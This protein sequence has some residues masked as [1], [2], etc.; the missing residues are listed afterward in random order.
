MNISSTTSKYCYVSSLL[1]IVP[2]EGKGVAIIANDNIKS[3]TLLIEEEPIITMQTMQLSM[4]EDIEISRIEKKV[5]ALSDNENEDYFS[6][7]AYSKSSL[8][9]Q[10]TKVLDIFRTNAYPTI[11]N[12]AGIFPII[13]RINHDCNPNVHYNFNHNSNRSTIYSIRDISKDKEITNSYIS[14]FL[15]RHERQNY[16]LENFGF[17]CN[18]SVCMKQGNDLIDSDNRRN[19]LM[20]LQNETKE[21]IQC[22]QR[23][24]LLHE[25]MI[26]SP[27]TLSKVEYDAYEIT[28]DI[29][30]YN[31]YKSSIEMSKGL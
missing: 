24:K 30:W 19:L 29:T 27:A 31:K 15:P 2:I 21:L 10:Y 9:C 8:L 20:M 12:N 1:K 25:E 14:L 7:H 18:C 16:L 22:E 6:L 4:T 26:D 28:K 11:T 3:G 13:S 5:K 23:L 17:K